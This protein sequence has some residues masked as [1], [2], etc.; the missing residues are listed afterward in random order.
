MEVDAFFKILQKF[1][2]PEAL[3][4]ITPQTLRDLW[5]LCHSRVLLNVP[6]LKGPD[7]GA[8]WGPQGRESS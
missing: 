5:Q 4:A 6:H 1:Q 2:E 3:A 7:E 8:L